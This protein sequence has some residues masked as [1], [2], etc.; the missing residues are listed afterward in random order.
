MGFGIVLGVA[1]EQKLDEPSVADKMRVKLE[2]GGVKNKRDK[3]GHFA[4]SLHPT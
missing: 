1:P 4:S 2:K 3:A